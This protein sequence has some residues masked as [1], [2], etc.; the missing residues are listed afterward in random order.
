[1]EIVR[2]RWTEEGENERKRYGESVRE[3]RE[4]ERDGGMGRVKERKKERARER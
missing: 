1:M 4:L 3:K 2:E